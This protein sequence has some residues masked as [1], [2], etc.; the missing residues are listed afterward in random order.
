[1]TIQDLLVANAGARLPCK[2][3]GGGHPVGYGCM[4]CGGLG[5]VYVLPDTV[6]IPCP[7]V[8]ER[9]HC[10]RL[11]RSDTPCP[12]QGRGWVPATDG[13]VWWRAIMPLGVMVVG[14]ATKAS[15]HKNFAL[16]VGEG[17]AELNDPELAFH[18]AL[19]KALTVL[20]ARFPASPEPATS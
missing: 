9:I 16:R 14:E 3:Y 2:G 8:N 17:F 13:W 1:M 20:G 4:E 12:C 7:N 19:N 10:L 15:N 18:T 5:L 11:M 6:R